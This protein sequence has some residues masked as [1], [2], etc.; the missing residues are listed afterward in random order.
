[1]LT[2]DDLKAIQK[3]IRQEVENEVNDVKS[4]LDYEIRMSRM[5]IQE[6]V[7]E[8]RDRVKNF[9]IKTQDSIEKLDKK[10]D[11]IYR[12]L[13]IEIEKVSHMLDKEN[14]ETLRRVKRI[15]QHLALPEEN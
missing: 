9:E 6:S 5:H 11:K 1:M 3:I 8:V 10:M 12:G 2:K 7:R 13:K 4:S 15:E 14:I